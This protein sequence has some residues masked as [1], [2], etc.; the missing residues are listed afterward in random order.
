MMLIENE[1]KCLLDKTMYESLVSLIN[2]SNEIN[3]TN[4]YYLDEKKQILYDGNTLRI[5]EIG[6]NKIL[7][8]KKYIANNGA[9]HIREEHELKVRY[10]PLKLDESLIRKVFKKE[11][12]N[13]NLIGKLETKRKVF[14]GENFTLCLD[15]NLYFE[16]IDYEI[17]IEFDS[18]IS[19]ELNKCIGLLFQNSIKENV[20]GKFFRF[21][22]KYMELNYGNT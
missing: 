14:H 22:T 9:L 3:Q 10:I 8:F 2:W 15:K 13:I 5:R 16:N 20:S 6:D 12:C 11:Y 19:D 17:E 18:N 7:Q 1:Y 4:F 21:Y